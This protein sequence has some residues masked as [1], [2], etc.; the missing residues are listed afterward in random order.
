ME[1]EIQAGALAA[2]KDPLVDLGVDL[3]VLQSVVVP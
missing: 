2:W 3:L 1:G